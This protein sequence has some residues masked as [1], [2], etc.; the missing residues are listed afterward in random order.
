MTPQPDNRAPGETT[1]S[2]AST[3]ADPRSAVDLLLRAV[4]KINEAVGRVLGVCLIAMALIQFMLVGARYLFA[5]PA[6]LGLPTLWWQE[7][8]VYLFG[9]SATLGLGYGL[10][11]GAHVR[12]DLIYGGLSERGKAWINVAGAALLLLPLSTLIVWAS[13]SGVAMAWST[14][15][16]SSETSGLPLRFLLK[17]AIPL[18]AVLLGLQG[19]AQMLRALSVITARRRGTTA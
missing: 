15:E 7:V 5:A 14:L 1:P 3:A 10:R 12:I 2:A 17:T 13:W 4:D 9:L 8:V 11:H 19:I 18:G 16:G 6:L